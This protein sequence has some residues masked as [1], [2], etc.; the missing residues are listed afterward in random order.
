[1]MLGSNWFK[2]GFYWV[3]NGFNSVLFNLLGYNGLQRV[4]MGFLL[5]NWV[6]TDCNRSS[7]V[8]TG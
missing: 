7:L 5:F 1:M 6:K 4:T 3:Q 2:M 8:K